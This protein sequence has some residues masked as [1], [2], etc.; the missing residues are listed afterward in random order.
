MATASGALP[1]REMEGTAEALRRLSP[2]TAEAIVGLTPRQRDAFWAVVWLTPRLGRSPTLRE[3]A[4][5]LDLSA[6]AT[7][8]TLARKLREKG[9]LISKPEDTNKSRL[10][11]PWR[12]GTCRACGHPLP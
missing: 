5:A 6:T 4:D 1:V 7:T 2:G 11:V 8:M 10:R 12:D 9:A 3:L